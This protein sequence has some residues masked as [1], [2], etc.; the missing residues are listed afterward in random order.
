MC[1]GFRAIRKLRNTF[2][3]EYKGISETLI[4]TFIIL[5][6]SLMDRQ[7]ISYSNI[8]IFA[9]ILHCHMGF[10]TM[11]KFSIVMFQKSVFFLKFWSLLPFIF[12]CKF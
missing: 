6:Q 1:F 9:L 12:Y 10:F 8:R 11:I 2:N 4:L 3:Y 7:I 5:R